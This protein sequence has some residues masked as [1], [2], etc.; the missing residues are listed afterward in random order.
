[1]LSTN[2]QPRSANRARFPGALLV[3]AA[4]MLLLPGS[5]R[6]EARTM[7]DRDFWVALRSSGFALPSGESALPLALEAAALLASTDPQLRDEVAYQAIETWVY[8]EQRLNAAELERL[9]IILSANARHGLGEETGD[10]LFLRSF[11]LLG[12][13]VLAAEDLKRPFLDARQFDGLL[14]LATAELANER[15]L[16]GY[17]PG[18]GWGHATAHCADLLKFLARSHW[19]RPEQQS[20]IVNAIAERLR[21]G[22]LVFVWGE[23]ARLAA[24]LTSVGTRADADPAPFMLWF[25]RLGEEHAALWRGTFEPARYVPVRAQLNALSALAADLDVDSS[26][27]GTIRA[28]LRSLRAE[29]Q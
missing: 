26:T 10:G 27:G 22:G 9:R 24:A 13:A 20:R 4:A 25:Q 8:R 11:S 16:R 17:V 1:M 23:D 15:D 7:H 5:G 19:L 6:T 12:L 2:L 3:A 21:S 29:A 18:K 28:A 14:E